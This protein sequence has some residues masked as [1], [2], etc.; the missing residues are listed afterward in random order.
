M[1]EGVNIPLKRYDI[2]HFNKTMVITFY[3]I[4]PFKCDFIRTLEK[5]L[6]LTEGK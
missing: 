4:R 2:S 1:H 3:K 6:I 5:L